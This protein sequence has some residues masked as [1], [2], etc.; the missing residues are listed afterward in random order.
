MVFHDTPLSITYQI[1]SECLANIIL[2]CYHCLIWFRANYQSHYWELHDGFISWGCLPHLLRL[3]GICG[4]VEHQ[5]WKSNTVYQREAPKY[6][7]HKSRYNPP[8]QQKKT[9]VFKLKGRS[10]FTNSVIIL[11]YWILNSNLQLFYL[12]V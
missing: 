2:I 8:P 9:W 1:Q 10:L 12:W 6:P 7:L 5:H 3:A 4:T 11:T